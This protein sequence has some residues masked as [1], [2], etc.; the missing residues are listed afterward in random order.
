MVSNALT[1]LRF[2]S[3]VAGL[4]VAASPHRQVIKKAFSLLPSGSRK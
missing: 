1:L 2:V 4:Y 3:V